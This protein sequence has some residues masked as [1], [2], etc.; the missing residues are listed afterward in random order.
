MIDKPKRMNAFINEA[1]IFSLIYMLRE[2]MKQS[3]FS[4]N[5]VEHF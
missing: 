1:L 2:K 3:I 5:K 4:I